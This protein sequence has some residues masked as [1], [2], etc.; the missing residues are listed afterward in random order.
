MVIDKIGALNNLQSAYS[1]QIRKVSGTDAKNT[2]RADRVEI[3][4]GGKLAELH[5]AVSAS[6]SKTDEVR[7]D[8]VE[9]AKKKLEDG[10]LVNDQVIEE[11]ASRIVDSLGI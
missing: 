4:S 10:T 11:I 1:S 8:K 7:Y 9:E 3:K 6:V 5:K 2:K